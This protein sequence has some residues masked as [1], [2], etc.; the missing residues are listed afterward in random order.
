MTFLD[1]GEYNLTF[2]GF[3]HIQKLSKPIYR[4][5]SVLEPV[6]GLEVVD[7]SNDTTEPETK[8][9]SVEITHLGTNSCLLVDYG[10]KSREDLATFGDAINCQRLFP[11]IKSVN[12]QTLTRIMELS[13]KYYKPR[14]YFLKFTLANRLSRVVRELMVTVLGMLVLL[15]NFS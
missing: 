13:K 8:R 10:E 4:H 1:A 12:N 15:V 6:G 14:D 2:N 9:L 7:L 3:N 5:I 11:S